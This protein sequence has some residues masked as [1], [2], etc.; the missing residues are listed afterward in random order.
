MT[1]QQAEMLRVASENV[2]RIVDHAL[3]QND[4][5]QRCKGLCLAFQTA[6]Q[7]LGQVQLVKGGG[8]T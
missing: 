6:H 7:L 4:L 2:S 5:E 1:A 3:A 8:T